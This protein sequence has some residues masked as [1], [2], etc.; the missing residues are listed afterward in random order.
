MDALRI[1]DQGNGWTVLAQWYGSE[2]VVFGPVAD[3]LPAIVW[4]RDNGW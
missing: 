1:I 2:R 3:V 4:A